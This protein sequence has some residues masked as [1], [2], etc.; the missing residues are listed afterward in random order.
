M[1]ASSGSSMIPSCS[2]DRPSSAA[3][4]SM[5]FDSTPRMTPDAI[6]RSLPGM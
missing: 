3:E 6:V 4:H 1:G 2:S 5:P